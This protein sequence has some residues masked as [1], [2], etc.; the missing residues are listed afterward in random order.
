MTRSRLILGILVIGIMA[1][2][3]SSCISDE[4]NSI[5]I[6]IETNGTYVNV[7]TSSWFGVSK[8]MESEIKYA[9][10]DVIDDPETTV[11]S[12]K[13]DIKAIAKKYKY[14]ADVTIIS[15]FG[16]DKLPMVA[17]VKGDSMY[18]TLKDGQSM[19]ILKTD[20]FK[21]GDIVVAYHPEYGM[22][23]KRLTKIEGDRVFLKSDN[24]QE[25][26]VGTQTYV[27]GDYYKV[28]QIKKVPLDTWLPKENLI[29][30]VKIY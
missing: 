22:I 10:L 5:K 12:L 30:V 24:R 11:E 21:V 23:V 4:S 16:E 8:Q 2:A 9:V 20:D 14:N 6:T 27:Y 1:V 28:E 3:I 7:Q 15:Q 18:P 17:V 13:R 26:V 29:G 25:E 19:V